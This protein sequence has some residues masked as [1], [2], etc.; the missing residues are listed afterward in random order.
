MQ[1]PS[2]YVIGAICWSAFLFGFA[3][4]AFSQCGVERWS[5][6]TGTDADVGLVNL[7][8]QTTTTI[9]ALRALA[10]P[11]SLPANNRIQPTESTVFVV[12]ATLTEYKLESDSDYHLVITDASGNT[13]IAEIPAPTCVGSGSPFASQI[14]VSRS[15]FDAKFNVTTSFQT[16]STPVR[17]T[18]V[19]FFDFLH[20]QTGV[21]P[22]GIE[23]HPVLNIVFNPGTSP[24]FTLTASN[25]LSIAAGSAGT[26][27]ILASPS[28]GF[29]STL[30][31]SA[32]GLPSG[33]TASFSSTTITGGSGSSNLTVNVGS[34]V[35]AGSYTVVVSA[36]GGGLTHTVNVPLTVTSGTGG[37]ELMT[38][39][40]FES[41][42]AS[43]NTAPGWTGTTTTSGQNTVIKGGSYPHAGT[44]Y[45]NLGGS[46]NGTDTLTQTVAIP[47]GSSP[48]LSFWVNI[49]L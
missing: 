17:I 36:T 30:T 23:I 38:D 15:T 2:K 34:S 12:D 48:T 10:Q 22:N 29:N 37:T 7:N 18:G 9:S 21:A 14:G 44:N 25:S 3:P 45:G 5:V 20:G 19:G 32:S 28:G 40:G 26:S 4:S 16:T 39:G 46:N 42:T 43:G 35:A 27:T 11:S 6:K 49:G 13:M 33:A 1:T 31:L 47:A 8:S 24:D 41:A